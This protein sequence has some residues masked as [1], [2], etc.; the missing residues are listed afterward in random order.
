MVL[1]PHGTAWVGAAG[2]ALALVG[3]FGAV[4]I[5][6]SPA[7]DPSLRITPNVFIETW[8]VTRH[9]ASIRPIWLSVLGLS[10]FWTIG[11]TLMTEFPVVA[12]DTLRS[13]GTVLTLLLSVFAI[14]VGVGSVQC[15]R[16]LHGEVSARLVPFAAL[17]ISAVLLGLRFGGGI[18]RAPSRPPPWR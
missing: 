5:P 10:W 7:A 16:L 6:A 9:A 18:R 14:G 15:A 1:L 2:V 12:R 3:L 11:A 4:R 13:D 8:R 17:G